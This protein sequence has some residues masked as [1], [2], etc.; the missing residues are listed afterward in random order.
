MIIIQLKSDLRETQYCCTEKQYSYLRSLMNKTKHEEVWLNRLAF[1]GR[2][3]LSISE[4]SKLINAI[5]KKQEFQI[6]EADKYI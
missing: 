4:A 6:L 1:Y 5:L 2:E 3:K